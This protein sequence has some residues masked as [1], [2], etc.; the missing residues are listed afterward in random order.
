MTLSMTEASTVAALAD[1][2]YDFLPASGNNATSFPL[3]AQR[4]G[5]GV[6]WPEG[7]SKRPGIVHLLTQTLEQR[8]SSFCPLILAIVQQS[9]SWRRGKQNPLSRAEIDQ[10]NSLLPGVSFKI[11]DLHDAGFLATLAGSPAPPPQAA[12]PAKPDPAKLTALANQL[13]E[14]TSLPPQARGYAFEK[15]LRDVFDVYGMAP[16]ASFKPMAGE[17]ID[18][19]FELDGETYV[20]EAKWQAAQTPA[21]DL[22]ILNGKLNSR[23]TWSRGLFISYGG[24]TPEGLAAFNQG[25]TSIIC[26]DGLDLHETLARGL[27]LD[28]VIAKKARRAVETGLCYISVRDLF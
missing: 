9:M 13:L 1:L 17:Q 25:R 19:S 3:A 15:F 12:E 20:L 22:H 4:V 18:G 23:P 14:I 21:A 16:R 6:L 26:M 8:R 10:L 24:F 7:A 5:V 11:P 2:L 28:R 27:M